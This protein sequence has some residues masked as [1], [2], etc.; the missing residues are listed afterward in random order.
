MNYNIEIYKLVNYINTN[1]EFTFV[2]SNKC[3]YNNHLGA[4]LADIILQAG[5]N[6]KSIVFPR[7]LNI[8]KS[9]PDAYSLEGLLNTLSL[10]EI[11]SFLQWKNEV[12]L[13]RYSSLIDFM[14]NNNLQDS[15]ELSD[16]LQKKNNQ[17]KFLNISGIGNK[18]LDYF[19]KLMHVETIAVDRHIFN[20]LDK[21]NVLYN[22]DYHIAKKIVEYTAD[23][24]SVSRRD[25]DFSIWNFMSDKNKQ[26]ILELDF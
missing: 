16:F 23:I 9:Y 14:I 12:K 8:Y 2:K 22:N 18:T 17:E 26:H 19:L 5:V 10:I 7:V 25:I 13:S 24:M 3:F 4:V 11:S 6:Y 21:A 20:F 15:Y 1:N